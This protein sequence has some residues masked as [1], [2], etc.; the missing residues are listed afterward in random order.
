[1]HKN[2]IVTAV[3]AVEIIQNNDILGLGGFVDCGFAEEVAI[4]L[5]NRFI[6]SGNPKDLTLYF[7]AVQGAWN[8]SPCTRRVNQTGD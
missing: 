4:A 7:A 3:E 2:K 6:E 8:K 5:E 1:M